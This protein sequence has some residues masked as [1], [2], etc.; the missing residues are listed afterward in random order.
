MTAADAVP[1]PA[2][3]GVLSWFRAVSGPS[4]AAFGVGILAVASG[5]LT[6]A[7]VMG[8]IPYTPT[9]SGLV[10]LVLIN[11]TLGLTL[12]ALIAWRLTRVWIA[13]RS[14]IAGAKLHAR[15]V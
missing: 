8:L 9:P 13:R 6:Y 12:A 11:L 5:V 3:G 14:G 10:W 15:L 7:T 4:R 2:T 1:A